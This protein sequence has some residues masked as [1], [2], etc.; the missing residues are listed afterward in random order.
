M[1]HGEPS[2]LEIGSTDAAR[3]RAFYQALFGW[4]FTSQDNGFAANLATT[5]IGVHGDDPTPSIVVYF[6]VD[7]IDAAVARVRALGG[8][9]PPPGAETAGF[10]RFV[11]CR[12]DQGVKFGLRQPPKP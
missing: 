12:D 10:G 11:E 9:A 7:D 4:T 1:T 8:T 6:G 2:F 3:G 5:G